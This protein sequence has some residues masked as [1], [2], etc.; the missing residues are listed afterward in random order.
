MNKKRV[1]VKNVLIFWIFLLLVGL[2]ITPIIDGNIRINKT[3]S[4]TNVI[5]ELKIF[6]YQL[7]SDYDKLL[8]RYEKSFGSYPSD[9]D[10]VLF[11]YPP[12]ELEWEYNNEN[13]NGT[14]NDFHLLASDNTFHSWVLSNFELH[15]N[16]MN[17]SNPDTQTYYRKHGAW[18]QWEIIWNDLDFNCTG[19]ILFEIIF[20]DCTWVQ[21][22]GDLDNDGDATFHYSFINPYSYLNGTLDGA[23]IF[24]SDKPYIVW[25]TPVNETPPPP[26]PN[27]PSKP[28]GNTSGYICIDHNYSASTT[29]PNGLNVSYGWDWN[30]D[31]VVDEW[32]DW[33]KS[34]ETCSITHNWSNPNDYRISVKAINEVEEESN[35][36]SG[37]NV[38]I[39]NHVPYSPHDPN[40]PTE[41]DDVP[42]NQI[43]C[44]SGGDPDI[45]D[46]VVYDVFFGTYPNPPIVSYHQTETCYDPY[47][48][49]EMPLYETFY[50]KVVAWDNHGANNESPLWSFKTGINTPPS[51]PDIDGPSQG[52]SGIILDYTFSSIDSENHSIKYKL[53]WGDGDIISTV[54]YPSGYVVTLSHIWDE[55]GTFLIKIKAID[56]YGLESN[57]SEFEVI[58]PRN[59]VA[60][61]NLY[62]GF[63]RH[64]PLLQRFLSVLKTN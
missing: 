43:L 28:S 3:D 10:F 18:Y 4:L 41:T 9:I 59:K 6:N 26:P 61:Y 34:N 55:I 32:T 50:W 17:F 30:S 54:F 56:E 5:E 58:I 60:F 33:Y 1:F 64:F 49:A 21:Y 47:G 63:F 27:A 36:S 45:C 48:S 38:T 31:L 51:D 12:D 44:W 40:P 24:D 35:W 52:N 2:S 19:E 57:W 16:G 20:L 62:I 39:K 23:H 25:Y 29:D 8:N 7:R 13:F 15:I 46:T 37:L 42:G 14:I 22:D 11:L 53:D